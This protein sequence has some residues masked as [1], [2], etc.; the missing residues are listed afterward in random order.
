MKRVALDLGALHRG[1]EEIQVEERVVADEHRPRAI[2]RAH[3]VPHD[4]EDLLQ[5]VEFG[6]RRPQRVVRIDAVDRERCRLEVRARERHD[7]IAHGLA[8][9]EG[10]VAAHLD[11]D[12]GDFQQRIRL[13]VETARFDVDDDGEK[14]AKTRRE[15]DRVE[16]RHGGVSP[17]RRQPTASPARYGTTTPPPNS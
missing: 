14:A 7:V 16:L 5:R 11:Q 3:R 15:R 4:L 12:R 9:R 17:A 6:N 1:V 8:A 10:A 13:R 2:G